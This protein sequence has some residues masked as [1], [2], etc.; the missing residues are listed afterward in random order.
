MTEFS[1]GGGPLDPLF[2]RMT[3]AGTKPTMTLMNRSFI[4]KGLWDYG[5]RSLIW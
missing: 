1:N 2:I 3:P 5:G 4:V